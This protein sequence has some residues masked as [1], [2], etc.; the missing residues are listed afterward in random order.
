MKNT[1]IAFIGAG[2]MA[3]S[4]IG[5]LLESGQPPDTLYVS[6]I[7][8]EQLKTLQSNSAIH[9]T[10]DSREAADAAEVVVLAVKPQIIHTVIENMADVL[11]RNRPLVV[12]IAAGV[13]E[14]DISRWI[15]EDPAV[16]RCMPN[17]PSLFGVGATALYANQAVSEA[18]K[19]L[20]EK[21]LLTAGTTDTV[22]SEEM[23]DAVTALSG[24]GPAYFF[25]MVES[26]TAA[27]EKL[28]LDQKLA[29]KLAIQTALGAATM[30]LQ[31]GDSPEQLR[32]NVTSKGGTTEAAINSFENNDL[33]E[34]VYKGMENAFKRSIELGKQLGDN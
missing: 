23:L 20:A 26:M 11:R 4:L 14:A 24:S 3:R 31:S 9:T 6:D 7:N 30:L 13:R 18:Q 29:Q 21:L 5:G 16:V 28:G 17:T 2:N 25:L 12:S 22:E 33:R 1:R 8:P 27:A 32:K 19:Q 34:I 10:Q 15:G